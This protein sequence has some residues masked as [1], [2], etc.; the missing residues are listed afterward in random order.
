MKTIFYSHSHY[1]I[2]RDASWI[3]K[4]RLFII[5]HLL[6]FYRYTGLLQHKLNAQ[7]SQ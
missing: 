7:D 5:Q 4:V 1:K 3:S 2:Y 6:T